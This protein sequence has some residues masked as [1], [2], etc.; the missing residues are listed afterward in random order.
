MEGTPFSLELKASKPFQSNLTLFLCPEI[1]PSHPKTP[2]AF[3]GLRFHGLITGPG[4]LARLSVPGT[5]LRPF[6]VEGER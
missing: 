6:S 2:H 1:P 5:F 4:G 3:Q